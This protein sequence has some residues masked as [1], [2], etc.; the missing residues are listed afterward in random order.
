MR[1]TL[2]WTLLVIAAT[3][4]LA[5]ASAAG[6][7]TSDGMD[8]KPWKLGHLSKYIG[9]DQFQP[10]LNDPHVREELKAIVGESLPHL[11]RNLED[12]ASINFIGSWM[13][14]RGARTNEAFRERAILVIDLFN[15]MVHAGIYSNGH[16]TVFSVK[17]EYRDVPVPLLEWVWSREIDEIRF[18]VPETN[19][20]YRKYE[21]K[22]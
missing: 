18:K 17:E 9:S 20:T 12:R 5:T 1:R 11:M 15:G 3:A 14:L 6:V 16:R 4:S 8:W 13:I 7:E 19:F 10:V 2:H 22:K 21:P